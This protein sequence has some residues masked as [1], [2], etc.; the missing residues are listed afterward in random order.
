MKLSEIFMTLADSEVSNLGFVENGEI[1][2]ESLPKILRAINL[3]LADIHTRF[4]L[5]KNRVTVDLVPDQMQYTIAEPD[6]VELLTSSLSNIDKS[7]LSPNTFYASVDAPTKI[8]VE[9]KATLP[10]LTE[11]DIA[12]D[13]NV[14]LPI[15]YLNALLYF[16]GSRMLMSI[17]NQMDGDIN[18]G[19]RYTQKYMEELA[20][21][22]QQGV[23]V[24]GI[25]ENNWF[26]ER[27][28]R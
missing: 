10:P 13:S 6:F 19:T 27:G 4:L 16:I 8:T 12:A 21:L 2:P 23:D 9:Y 3:G 26:S 5:R 7:L 15:A 18:E 17:P 14:E 28:F 25:Y 11:A 24:D 1:L 20:M 22:A